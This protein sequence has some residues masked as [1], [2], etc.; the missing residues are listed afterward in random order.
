MTEVAKGIC[1]QRHI[2][3]IDRL[4]VNGR[5]R[6]ATGVRADDN[7]YAKYMAGAYGAIPKL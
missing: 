3:K 7:L 4:V 5:K 6:T 1:M 2:L